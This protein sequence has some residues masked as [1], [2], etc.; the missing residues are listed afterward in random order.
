M[1]RRTRKVTLLVVAGLATAGALAAATG[2]ALAA[3]N[4]PPAANLRLTSNTNVVDFGTDGRSSVDLALRHVSGVPVQ[5][6][7]LTL[8]TPPAVSLPTFTPEAQIEEPG[9]VT[10][11]CGNSQVGSDGLARKVCQ[12]SPL[13]V[14]GT[15]AVHVPLARIPIDRPLGEVRFALSGVDSAGQAI[16][17]RN[18]A[19]RTFR[20]LS[21]QVPVPIVD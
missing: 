9:D 3:P 4:D 1:N 13:P 12:L 16:F 8:T 14:G 6:A 15:I 11:T 17:D 7:I 18:G 21:D 10:V 19:S 2:N 20:V 5:T